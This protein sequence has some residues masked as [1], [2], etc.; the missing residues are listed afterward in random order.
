MDCRDLWVCVCKGR[1]GR[2]L[3]SALE[4]ER[5][6]FV[7]P[8]EQVCLK[9]RGGVG[10]L[11]DSNLSGG[12]VCVAAERQSNTYLVIGTSIEVY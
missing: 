1:C 9:E 8:S 6:A 7:P 12:C 4:P 11:L 5:R 2:V 10:S 3:I